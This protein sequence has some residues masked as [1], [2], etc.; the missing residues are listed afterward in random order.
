[1]GKIPPEP[2]DVTFKFLSISDLAANNQVE[3]EHTGV[4]ENIT[5]T[6]SQSLGGDELEISG[7][8]ITPGKGV[9]S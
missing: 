5:E 2:L 3:V 9:R 8:I 6:W 7:R 4:I 1:M